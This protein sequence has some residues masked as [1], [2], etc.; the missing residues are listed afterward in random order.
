M[1]DADAFFAELRGEYLSAVT[2][3]IRDYSPIKV[4]AVSPLQSGRRRFKLSFY[5]ANYPEGV[6]D[7]AYTLQ[8]LERGR[9]FLLARSTDHQPSRLLL[10][11]PITAQWLRLHFGLVA[12]DSDELGQWLDSNL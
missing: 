5:H 1:T 12:P 3:G 9:R 8:T 2:T 6:R 7:K 10:I 4:I 11:Y